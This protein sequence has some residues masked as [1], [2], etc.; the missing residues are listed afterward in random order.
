MKSISCFSRAVEDKYLYTE[1]GTIIRWAQS[2]A[3][4][5]ATLGLPNAHLKIISMRTK[6]VGLKEELSLH[7]RISASH[8][9]SKFQINNIISHV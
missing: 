3:H 4:L 7:F 1:G 5:I 9:S 6:Q 8:N 2:H